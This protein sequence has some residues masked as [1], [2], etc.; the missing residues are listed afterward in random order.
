M[1][2]RESVPAHVTGRPP[3][4]EDWLNRRLYHPLSARLANALA[5]TPVTP[6]AVSVAG[7]ALVVLA[8]GLYAS[9]LGIAAA[10]AGLGIHMAWHVLDGADGDLARMTGR[11]SAAG[12]IVDG[13]SD[14][15]S[16]LVL[17]IALAS[18]LAD[19]IG[20]AGW[21]LMIAA[22]IARAFQT[23]FY[24]TQRRQYGWWVHGSAWLR[25]GE[26][27]ALGAARGP[28]G[29][30]T[31][32][33]LAVSDWMARGGRALDTRFERSDEAGREALR[34]EVRRQV[35]PVVRAAMPLS[36]NIRTIVIGIAMIAG[37][38]ILIVV[39]E[40]VVLS[41]VLA[42]LADR[43]ERAIAAVLAAQ[44]PTNSR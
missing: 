3:E 16:H 36:S 17:Y 5:P 38:P 39:F 34:K 43:A 11:A 31:R 23:T 2:K 40:L 10:A 28:F 20:G 41:L 24:E 9:G 25:S 44:P 29:G 32:L 8:A 13:A 19:Q 27:E 15:L 42:F 37:L 33:Y 1:S 4:L 35:L 12:E 22:G 30:L 21:L 14:Y 26:E 7:G 18:V 6:N